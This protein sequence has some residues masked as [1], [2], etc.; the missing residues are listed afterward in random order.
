MLA[1]HDL[2]TVEAT[3]S[4]ASRQDIG[5]AHDALTPTRTLAAAE[6]LFQDGDTRARLYRVESGAIC[7]YLRWADGRHEVIEMAFPGDIIGFGNLGKHISTAQAMVATSVRVVSLDEFEQ[8]LEHDGQLAARLAAAADREFELLRQRTLRQGAVD[9]VGRVAAFLAAMSH[10]SA[11]EGRDPFVI[12]DSMTCGVVAERLQM[13]VDGLSD[14]LVELDR[15]GL[16]APCARGLR[17]KNVAALEALA[18]AA[19]AD[20]H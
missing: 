11:R 19:L 5:R 15:R 10:M 8:A 13:T 4:K 6:I 12:G 18:D 16:V 14:A 7:H 1:F 9:P 20:A 2:D 3:Q 17:L